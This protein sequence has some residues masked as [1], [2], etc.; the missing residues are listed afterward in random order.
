MTDFL[1]P[2]IDC[3]ADDISILGLAYVGDAVFELMART[4]FCM[5]GF[6][7]ARRLHKGT[8]EL[9]CAKAQ[10]EAMELLLPELDEEEYSI[11]KR[12]RNARVNSVPRGCTHK[13][14][15]FSTGLEALFGYLYLRGKTDRLN[16]LFS[17][18]TGGVRLCP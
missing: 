17:L 18:I 16:D 10:A 8:L 5:Q 11:F 15:H 2:N 14:Y 4:N 1:S 3:A 13:Q 12:G 7:S 9:V 6:H